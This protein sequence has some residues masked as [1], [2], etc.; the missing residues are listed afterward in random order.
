MFNYSD[1]F[2]QAYKQIQ[3][4]GMTSQEQ[5][6][7]ENMERFMTKLVTESF[8][9]LPAGIEVT[10]LAD[11]VAE[12]DP[13]P[14]KE[15]SLS[16]LDAYKKVLQQSESSDELVDE[17]DE[18]DIDPETFFEEYHRLNEMDESAPVSKKRKWEIDESEE[19]LE[20]SEEDQDRIAEAEKFIGATSTVPN[21]S[22]IIEYMNRVLKGEK[23]PRDKYMMPIVHKS[24]LIQIGEPSIVMDKNQKN[25]IAVDPSDKTKA[26]PIDLEL[27]K[28]EL[29]VR[30]T[31]ILSQNAKMTKT[32]GEDF[33]FMNFGIP[34]LRGLAVDESSN[35]FVIVNTCPGAGSCKLVC[36][37]LKGG[38]VQY[39]NVFKKQTRM[40]N[41]LLNDPD[42]FF[43]Q[44]HKEVSTA[45]AKFKKKNIRLVV[46]WHDA[47]DFFSDEYKQLFFEVV[48]KN[49]DV[50]FYAY[51]KLAD[52]AT[53]EK[54]DNFIINFSQGALRS[55]EKQIDVKKTKT[56][57]IVPKELFKD[58]LVHKTE[59]DEKGKEEKFW[60]YKSDEA[61]KELKNRLADKYDIDASS[62]LSYDEMTETPLGEIGQYNVIVMAGEGDMSASRKDVLGTYLLVH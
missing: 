58:L 59:K 4:S 29:T 7:L 52:V 11:F 53:G 15:E 50:L 24:L 20:V 42:G 3:N 2:Y 54:P 43:A 9:G 6:L 26:T 40:L 32:G 35:K 36:Y 25:A 18:E 19:P 49:P 41:F 16:P 17:K 55:Q 48:R 10:S 56:S 57:V 39:P 46:R 28:K 12:E 38:Y 30:P 13:T 51:T 31:T 45:A 8:A 37:A 47:G 21:E 27:L 44:V 23:T 5:Q 62:I 60:A 61:L 33:M 14:K 22:E 1:S 34:A